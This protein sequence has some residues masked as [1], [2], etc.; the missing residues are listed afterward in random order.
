MPFISY[1][2]NFEDVMLWRALGQVEDGFYIDIGA[3][4]PD[5]DSVTRAFS[6]R[7]WRGIN[8]EPLQAESALLRAARPRDITLQVAI[9]A[10]AGRMPFY[11]VDGTGLSTLDAGVAAGYAVGP[12]SV[13][14]DSIEVLTLAQICALYAA[15]EIHFL[16][17]DVEGAERAVLEGADLIRFRPW[18]ILAEATA[19]GTTT[20]I[21]QHWE[22]LLLDAEYEFVWFDGLNRF[23]VS[24]ERAAQLRPAFATP[25]NTFDDFVRATDNRWIGK[26]ADEE[27]QT[28]V[29][30][31]QL[32]SVQDGLQQSAK[33]EQHHVERAGHDLSR[34]REALARAQLETAHLEAEAAGLRHQTATAEYRR[35]LMH[36]DLEETKA[37]LQEARHELQQTHLRLQASEAELLQRNQRLEAE[38]AG[39]RDQT[40]HADHRY[41]LMRRDLDDTKASLQDALRQTHPCLQT[42][43]SELLQRNQ[44]LQAEIAGP[45]D[46]TAPADRR[47]ELMRQELDDT[48]ASLQDA[49]HA[50]QQTE[51]RLQ[52]LLRSRSWR[53]T[54]PLRRARFWSR[55]S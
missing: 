15:P 52:A 47:Y 26:F 48:K 10:S 44:R 31:A 11:A 50:L 51:L 9:G 3:H 18:I 17:I 25:P 5:L 8:V 49:R 40:A 29:L 32:Q 14:Q 12:Y 45:R 55:T 19:P 34:L 21:H 33:R 24:A 42:S 28:R 2:Q 30:R 46:Q 38:I 16:K 35:D 36:R 53:I 27:L 6:D 43:E 37:R 39:S 13:R 41:E 23:Y 54:A 7:G 22:A 1:A 4:H 20:P